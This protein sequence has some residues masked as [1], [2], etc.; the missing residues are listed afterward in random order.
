MPQLLHIFFPTVLVILKKDITWAHVFCLT[1][2]VM[3]DACN[4]EAL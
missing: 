4:T 1:C 2:T 3:H